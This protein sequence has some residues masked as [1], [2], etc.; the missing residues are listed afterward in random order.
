M[1]GFQCPYCSMIMPITT[2]TTKVRYPG[3]ISSEDKFHDI[4]G[5]LVR[6][7]ACLEIKFYRCPN[8]EE[9]TVF[10]KGE[11]SKVSD[12]NTLIRP[13]SFAKQFPEY[14]PIAIRNDYEEAC[15]IVNLS[16]KAS[17]T[18]S[19]RCLQG[20]IRDFWGITGKKRLIDE[21]DALED[22]VPASQ[23]KVLSSLRR[24]GNIGAH[25]E[26]DVNLIIDIEPDDAQKLIS[27]IE[28]LIK[29]WYIERHEQEQLYADI[30]ALD[31]ET[32]S[33]KNKE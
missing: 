19:R 10:A 20:M 30:L 28:L 5:K 9:Y 14:I 17:A 18:L 1:S 29:Q 8:C 13:L 33:Q 24:I 12:V 23:W 26:A 27:V 22:K 31:E 7:E 21:I 16:P 3:F 2:D 25:P 15:A 11:G 32:T 6:K 4:N